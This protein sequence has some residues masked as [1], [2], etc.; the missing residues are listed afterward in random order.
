MLDLSSMLFNRFQQDY[1]EIHVYLQG[2]IVPHTFCNKIQ[3]TYATRADWNKYKN[4]CGDRCYN[5]IQFLA[6]K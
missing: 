3:P 6:F 1:M 5:T 4:S 2:N